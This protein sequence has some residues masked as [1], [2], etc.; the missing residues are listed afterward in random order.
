MA[1]WRSVKGTVKAI[2]DKY[3]G[4]LTLTGHVG[5][6]SKDIWWKFSKPEYREAAFYIPQKG[7]VVELIADVEGRWVKSIVPLNGQSGPESIPWDDV[8][9]SAYEGI[10]ERDV[11]QD[12]A[13]PRKSTDESI[14]LQ[15]AVK[16]AGEIM[17]AMIAVGGY[18]GLT[19]AAIGAET[20]ALASAIAVVYSE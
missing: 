6:D 14:Q 19:T 13:K 7:E 4:A 18:S 3:G 5:P 17:C 9:L 10:P 15:V 12:V 16:V 8:P 1:D 2:N 20:A 11:N